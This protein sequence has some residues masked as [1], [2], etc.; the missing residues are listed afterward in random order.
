MEDQYGPDSI[1][2]MAR[3]AIFPAGAY[4][5]AA[6]QIAACLSLAGI[7]DT[8]DVLDL[9]CGPGRHSLPLARVGHRVVAVD[10]T[11]SY[12]QL[13]REATEPDMQLE[14]VQAD[15][16]AFV[17]PGAFDLALNLYHSFGYFDDPADDARVLANLRA[18]LRPGGALVMDLM[19]A[20]LLGR[21]FAPVRRRELDDG[22]FIQEE[23]LI[24]EDGRW[25]HSTWIV[26]REGARHAF[27]MSHRLYA[28]P[29]LTEA[30]RV[31]GFEA[32]SLYGGF[33][34]RPWDEEAVRLVVVARRPA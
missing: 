13:V 21:E 2:A 5:A 14:V 26:E 28:A 4:D 15:M 11:P 19:S 17:R 18:S 29:D 30:L 34:G 1:W 22:S 16:R 20:E 10:R 31:A 23:S 24:A 33:D 8:A 27:D 7:Q 32:P 25:L 6:G 3:D 9:P 12:L